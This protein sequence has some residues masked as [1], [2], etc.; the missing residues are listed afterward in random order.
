MGASAKERQQLVDDNVSF[1]RA[2]AAKLKESLPREVEF[3]DLVAYG[4][5]GLL[6]AAERYERRFGVAFT[7]FAWYRVRG[8]MFDGLRRMGYAGRDA[9]MKFEER[10]NTYLGNVTDRDAGA[11]AD[12][13][14]GE[15][16][17]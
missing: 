15:V 17:L 16:D 5:E 6:E 3:D 13:G 8:A 4:M 7:T 10:A 12:S 1:V 14:S 2:A 11:T 9:A